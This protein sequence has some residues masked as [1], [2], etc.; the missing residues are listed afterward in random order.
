LVSQNITV[1]ATMTL[2]LE[3]GCILT[4]DGSN[5]TLTINGT[6]EAGLYQIFDWGTGSG[7]VA[8]G[9]GSVK[10]VYPDWWATNTTPGTTD[11]TDALTSA[12]ATGENVRLLGTSYGHT[13]GLTISTHGQ[14]LTGSGM[15]ISVLKKLSGVLI[16]LTI[17]HTI[18]YVELSDF[19]IDNNS[20]AG[21]CLKTGSHYSVIQRLILTGTAGTDYALWIN[22]GNLSHYKDLNIDTN[23][24]GLLVNDTGDPTY[25]LYYS[26]FDN[27]V[28]AGNTG[29]AVSLQSAIN[30][31]F[32]NLYSE[33]EIYLNDNLQDIKFNQLAGELTDT[34]LMI[35]DASTGSA[36]QNIFVDGVKVTNSVDSTST[37]FFQLHDVEG[38]NLTNARFQDDYSAADRPY[39][40]MDGVLN[41]SIKQVVIKNGSGNAHY[42]IECANTRSDYIEVSDVYQSGAGTITNSLKFGNSVIRFSNIAQAFLSGATVIHCENVTGAVDTSNVLYGMTLIN[43]PTVTDASFYA[44]RFGPD[45]FVS[46]VETVASGAEITIGATSATGNVFNISGTTSITSIASDSTVAGRVVV[47]IFTGTAGAAGLTHG[48]N[49]VLAGSADFGYTPNDTIELVCNGTNWYE[50]SRSVN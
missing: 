47:L 13:G 18:A 16:G 34:S 36:I 42:F 25:G 38:F 37:P 24:A 22:G 45:G 29:Y 48:N 50:V 11:M 40:T 5:A 27:I 41:S 8:F 10:E 31:T 26:A 49:L 44:S 7:A 12:L 17:N 46:R 3:R 28:S 35:I 21:N 30:L 19:K 1:P 43:C 9:D 39:I 4:D 2:K 23:Y 33:Q 20:L 14:K 15:Y 6:F 32:N